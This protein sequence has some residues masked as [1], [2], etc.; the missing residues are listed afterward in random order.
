MSRPFYLYYSYDEEPKLVFDCGGVKIWRSGGVFRI[1][2]ND[3]TD[4][5]VRI[6]TFSVSRW[7]KTGS[8]ETYITLK[9]E[10]AHLGTVTWSGNDRTEKYEQ[11]LN[12]IAGAFR[13]YSQEYKARCGSG[14]GSGSSMKR[15]K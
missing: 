1:V 4:A 11:L 12:A 13:E 3:E 8:D 14:A 5:Y 10:D 15:H 9:G 7:S 2:I 6:G